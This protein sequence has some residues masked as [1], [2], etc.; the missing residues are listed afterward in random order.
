MKR[1]I[2]CLLLCTLTG[3]VA[4]AQILKVYT[5]QVETRFSAAAVGS[6]PYSSGETLTILGKEYTLSDIDSITVEEG[7]VADD[8]VT[9]DYDGDQA[10]VTL[11]G[12]IAKDMEVSLSGAHVVLL[13][14][15]DV[16]S[17]ITYTLSG[18]SDNGSL[19]MDGELKATFVLNGLTL[20]NPDSAAINIR[21]GKRIEVQLVEGT[22]TT[23]ED[24]SGG[25]WKG[26]FMVKGHTEFKGAGELYLTGNTGHAFWGK[27]YV[28]VK[29]SVGTITVLGAESDGFNVNQYFL[30]NGG[31]ITMSNLG[32]DG[33]A[34]AKTDDDTDEQNGQV[35][36]QAGTLNIS[37]TANAAK[38]INCED[39][40][41]IS[42]GD[43]T[44]KTTGG[45]A[46]DSSDKD[47][48]ACAGIKGDTDVFI[49]GGTISATSTGKGGKGISCD[50]NL[51]ITGG[52]ITVSTSGTRYT[53]SSSLTKSPKG[54]KSDGA[55]YL[56][57]GKINVTV[58]GEAT[59]AEGIESKGAM[60]ISG[61]TI[62]VVAYDDGINSGGNMYIQ[63]GYIYSYSSS[64]DAIDSNCNMYVQGGIIVAEGA[65]GAEGGLDANEELNYALY[66][67]GGTFIAMGGSN[68][69]PV[70][71]SSQPSLVYD[72]SISSGTTMALNNS[73]G[74]NILAFTM[75][76]SY[77]GTSSG[78][79]NI[80]GTSSSSCEIIMSSPD[81][82]T[83]SSYTLYT[84][85]TVSSG[86]SWHG[87]YAPATLSAT[88]SS[89]A[90]VSSLASPYST[91]TASSSGGGTTGPGGSTGGG[92][93]GPG[94]SNGGFGSF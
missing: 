59:A 31:T 24:G 93:T 36:I 70:S 1:F 52:D 53:Y 49:T 71:G 17:E 73:S 81:L 55:M 28:E 90:T 15:A 75:S 41:T 12:N 48:K 6:M 61:D 16:A 44:I 51:F 47:V 9:V 37:V 69:M 86:T 80:G 10:W 89:A 63:G 60:Y 39:S 77:T 68:S 11:A 91:M 29:K 92:S 20:T 7:S 67:S 34:V 26:C 14:G 94:G 30:M 66:V 3:L 40:I 4:H 46:Y 38:G 74:T 88:G 8:W 18:S 83:G 5:G 56:T 35:I 84:G 78:M 27:E 23:L 22:T 58:S 43:I 85:S 50:G 45:G 33:I 64:N 65:T 25:D 2:I 76:R 21:D 79:G 32:D 54:I 87:L 72:S 62:E 82:S 19:Y 57:G 42:G 13:Q